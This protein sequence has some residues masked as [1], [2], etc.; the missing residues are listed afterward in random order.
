M[1]LVPLLTILL[2]GV[3]AAACASHDDGGGTPLRPGSPGAP[4]ASSGGPD[5]AQPEGPTPPPP[6]NNVIDVAIW[7]RLVRD[8]TTQITRASDAELCRRLS[9]DLV[10]TVPSPDEL[11]ACAGKSPEEM[12]RA[13]MAK[14]AFAAREVRLWIQILGEDPVVMNGNLLLSGDKIL[15]RLASGALGYDD[16]VA[17]IVSHPIVTLNR[18]IDV[19]VRADISTN[20]FTIF[21]GRAPVGDEA[22]DFANLFRVW[23]RLAAGDP[24]GVIGY[25]PHVAGLDP[26]MCKDPV[27]GNE[28]CTSRALGAVTTIQLPD[29][30][31]GTGC[32]NQ[33]NLG[34]QGGTA[35]PPDGV[36]CFDSV[37]ASAPSAVDA[38]GNLPAALKQELEK[39]GRLLA[40]RAEFWEQAGERALMRLLGWWKSSLNEPDTVVPEVR[41]ALGAWFH[42]Q[43]KHDLRDLYATIASSLLYTRTSLVDPKD[44]ARVDGVPPWLSGPTKAMTG[45]QYLDSVIKGLQRKGTVAE[46]GPCDPHVSSDGFS[47]LAYVYYFPAALRIPQDKKAGDFYRDN[48]T[49]LGACQGGASS[50]AQPGLRSLFA[51]VGIGQGLCDDSAVLAPAGTSLTD[52][53]DKTIDSVTSFQFQQLLQ[54]EPEGAEFDAARKL[55]KDCIGDASCGATKGYAGLLCQTLLRSASFVF[56]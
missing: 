54:R 31:S 30:P 44:S 32:F 4:G 10:G 38:Q 55:A 41:T 53:S 40:S 36:L 8:R 46:T 21:L 23:K 20:V 28:V 5:Q 24:K 26:R 49:L 3:V 43:Q 50:Q 7:P 29:N 45:E 11:S 47:G 42:A 1:K 6:S 22:N 39:P 2:S 12:A 16:F 27:F 13:F 37:G 56:Y 51:Q 18:R 9:L 25:R 52:T 34:D 14:P 17:Q 33:F 35:G 19:D 15:G 48:A